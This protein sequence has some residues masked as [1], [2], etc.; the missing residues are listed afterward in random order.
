[1][2]R[3]PYPATMTKPSKQSEPIELALERPANGGSAVGHGDDGRVVFCDGGLAGETVRV[4]LTT[5]KKSFARGH[6][7][8]VLDPAPGRREPACPTH[9]S[10]CGGCDLAHATAETQRQIKE[11]VV[12]D[13]MVRIGRMDA[14]VVDAALAVGSAVRHTEIPDRYRTTV[15]LKIDG[16][17]A[18]YRRRSS[19]DTIVP[20]TCLV[21]HPQLENLITNVRFTSGAGNEAVIRISDLTKDAF[22]MVNGDPAAVDASMVEPVGAL[23]IIAKDNG[24]KTHMTEHAGGRDWQVSASSFFQAGPQVASALVDAVTF[25]AGDLTDRD[26]VDAYAGIGL[27]AG[28]V[29]ATARSVVAVE[30]SMSSTA[31]ARVNLEHLDDA[32]VVTEAVDDWL[33][34]PANTVIADPARAGLGRGGVDALMGCSA[35]RFVLVSCDTGSLGRDVQ[36]LAAEGYA[37]ES[38]QVIDAFHDTSHAEVVVALQR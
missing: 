18:G 21:V 3:V 6:V 15:R 2:A 27:F 17:R 25:A 31:D 26:L 28:T 11:H 16:L 19:H 10:G 1:M 32:A 22:V 37:I 34:F 38:V 5:Q 20:D 24:A 8:E 30:Q 9:H 33:A 4:Q 12:R 36:L 13:A 35:D 23:S 14:D 29:G 7:I